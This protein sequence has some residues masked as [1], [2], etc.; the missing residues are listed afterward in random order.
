M[1]YKTSHQCTLFSIKVLD[2]WY[3]VPAPDYYCCYNI[4]AN[5]TNNTRINETVEFIPHH[6]ELPVPDAYDCA[7]VAAKELT[8]TLI[9][10]HNHPPPFNIVGDAQHAALKN[11]GLSS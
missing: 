7:L 6:Y 2:V 11:L 4:Y 10:P 8:K 1:I 3:V 9:Y 5:K